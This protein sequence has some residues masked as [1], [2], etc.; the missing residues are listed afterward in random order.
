MI[1][2]SDMEMI[3]EM[4]EVKKYE[5][6]KKSDECPQLLLL[7]T[8]R[9]SKDDINNLSPAWFVGEILKARYLY[10]EHFYIVGLN[11]LDHIVCFYEASIGTQEDVTV[12]IKGIATFVLLAGVYKFVSIHNHP[13]FECV[14]SDDDLE[15]NKKLF[16]L[17]ETIG[18]IYEKSFIVSEEFVCELDINDNY[19]CYPIEYDSL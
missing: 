10:T 2:L 4:E 5:L 17:G 18:V 15:I 8:I 1:D 3:N 7:E 14:P 9:F 11:A 19:F 6:I 16:K 13:E 12:F